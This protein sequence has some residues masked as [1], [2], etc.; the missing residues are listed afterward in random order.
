MVSSARRKSPGDLEMVRDAPLS[1]SCCWGRGT[2]VATPPLSL[3]HGLGW[4]SLIIAMS[5][6]F[7]QARG[8]GAPSLLT[9]LRFLLGMTISLGEAPPGL[10]AMASTVLTTADTPNTGPWDSPPL[11]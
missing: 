3:S 2:D 4:Q 8:A 5:P 1:K 6:S 7:S 10:P 11:L 9:V